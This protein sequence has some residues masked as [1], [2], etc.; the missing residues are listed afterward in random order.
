LED[1]AKKRG[2]E[3]Q[4][5]INFRIILVKKNPCQKILEGNVYEG[6]KE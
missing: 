4:E 5:T 1:E 3:S 2:T 6:I